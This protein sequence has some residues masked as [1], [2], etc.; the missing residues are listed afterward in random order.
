MNSESPVLY[1]VEG[2]IGRLTLNRPAQGN[3]ISLAFSAAFAEAVEQ[4]VRAK[5]RVVV[6]SARG[7]RFCA[8]GDIAE[9]VENRERLSAHIGAMLVLLNPAMKKLAAL[10]APVI[11]VV[12]GGVGG[13]GIALAC[14]ADFVL[15]SNT[16]RVRGGYSAIGLTPDIGASYYA[17]QRIGAAKAKRLFILNEMFEAEQ[18]LAMGLFDELHTP[19]KLTHAAE[20]LAHTLAAGATQAFA[21]IKRLC[22]EANSRDVATHLD[23]ESA[24]LLASTQSEDARE[25]VQAFIDKRPPCFS[26]R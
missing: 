24:G 16:A 9:L 25:G 18:C 17:T 5:P 14:C 23:V 26:G 22:D 1:S 4:L 6:L 12:H 19:D 8:G 21:R 3:A 11:S 7:P 10:P 2:G 15:A 20:T 13:A